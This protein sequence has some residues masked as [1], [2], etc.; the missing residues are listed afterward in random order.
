MGGGAV[1]VEPPDN[2][3]S[4]SHAKARRRRDKHAPAARTMHV[5]LLE[6][7]K[8]ISLSCPA[9]NE[10]VEKCGDIPVTCIEKRVII[11]ITTRDA[12]LAIGRS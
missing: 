8:M 7:A 10:A 4:R 9:V 12:L 3:K 6:V 11:S 2:I 5:Q 1:T